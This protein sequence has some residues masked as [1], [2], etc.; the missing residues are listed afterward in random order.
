MQFR[1]IPFAEEV[2]RVIDQGMSLVQDGEAW[3]PTGGKEGMNILVE[4]LVNSVLQPIWRKEWPVIT[5]VEDFLSWLIQDEE[6]L[7]RLVELC[8]L[9]RS[10]MVP[11]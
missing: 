2:P 8:H 7:S 4:D 6:L 1:R 11:K 10:L 5:M 9:K 3:R